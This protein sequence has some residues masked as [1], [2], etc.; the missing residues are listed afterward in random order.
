MTIVPTTKVQD[1]DACFSTSR[2]PTP[3]NY[4]AKR[5]MLRR[6]DE[7]LIVDCE[8]VKINL[9]DAVVVATGGAAA[10]DSPAGGQVEAVSATT[11]AGGA[12]VAAPSVPATT[13]SA[14]TSGDGF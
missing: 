4:G 6:Y 9:S 8:V 1:N 2:Q 11:E 14:A 5:R 12:A 13:A 3:S 7:T 10:E